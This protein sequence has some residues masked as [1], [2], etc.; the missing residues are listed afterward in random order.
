MEKQTPPPESP[1][2]YTERGTSTPVNTQPEREFSQ[3]F[4]TNQVVRP[5]CFSLPCVRERWPAAGGTEGV[6]LHLLALLILLLVALLP[7][8]PALA[9][10]APGSEMPEGVTFDEVNEI[11]AQMY[12]PVCEMEPLD[13]CGAVTCVRWRE[14]IAEQLA[15]GLT[16]DEIIAN[17]VARYGDRVVG[18][19]QDTG[20]R[21][22]SLVGP[23]LAFVTAGG[24]GW[25]TF[26]RWQDNRDTTPTGAPLHDGPPPD[27]DPYR[28]RLEQDLN[29]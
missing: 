11:A 18:V 3:Q 7:A 23:L 15:D 5:I 24:V 20:L 13:T 22:L 14:E 26:R 12:C 19:P 1:S 10:D 21:V 28:A 29:G 6:S 2:P 4:V 27:D 8:V 9:Q 17:F 25:V 16:E